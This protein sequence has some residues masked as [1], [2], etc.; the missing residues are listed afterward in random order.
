MMSAIR[1]PSRGVRRSPDAYPSGR[2]GSPPGDAGDGR[3]YWTSVQLL[4]TGASGFV[5][6]SLVPAL[7]DAG[8]EV[9]AMTRRPDSYDGPGEPVR[10]DVEDPDSLATALAG[11]EVAYYLVHSLD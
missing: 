3:G 9:R 6:R 7:L 8:H 10:G 5:G 4:V 11:C 1:R 2:G